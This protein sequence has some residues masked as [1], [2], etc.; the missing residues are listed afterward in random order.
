M[1]AHDHDAVDRAGIG[2]VQYQIPKLLGWIF[3]EQATSDY[4]VDGHVEVVTDG[5]P[6]GRLVGLQIKTGKSQFV[7][8]T[9]NGWLYRPSSRHIDYWLR[10][11]LPVYLLLV[12]TDKEAIHWQIL[13]EST[14]TRGPRGGRIVEVPE[15]NTIHNVEE[16]WEQAASL[17]GSEARLR[18]TENLD[19]LPPS[20]SKRLSRLKETARIASEW[21]AAH[22]AMGRSAPELTARTLLAN[23]PSWMADL[24]PEAWLIVGHYA[25][26][27]DAPFEAADA[28]ERA[29][30]LNPGIE[31]R[32]KFSAGG[33][34]A[35]VDPGRARDLF[36]QASCSQDASAIGELGLAALELGTHAEARPDEE[37]IVRL[38]ALTDD[39]VALS[40]LARHFSNLGQR[41]EAV[42][43]WES[44]LA[45]DPDNA[46]IFCGLSTELDRRA[47][48]ADRRPGDLARATDLAREAVE[49]LH[50][51]SGPSIDALKHLLHLLLL[52]NDYAGILDRALAAPRG[53]ATFSEASHPE[54]LTAAV[55]AADGLGD[56]ELVRELSGRLPDG[57]YQDFAKASLSENDRLPAKD[58]EEIWR[59]V[60]DGLD[61]SRP[62]EL[63]IT[64][65]R[66]AHLGV[67]ATDRLVPLVDAQLV[68]A[69]RV[70]LIRSIAAA[71]N[72]LDTALPGF[73]AQADVD[74]SAA[75]TLI[76]LLQ[77][78]GRMED[79]ITATE[80]A[81]T[82]FSE[83][84]FSLLQADLL[85]A[86]SRFD[87]ASVVLAS[88][89]R[90]ACS[91]G[92][93]PVPSGLWG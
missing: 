79:A 41:S 24:G 83:P 89:L 8:K 57:T 80:D 86:Q 50:R 23:S 29:A 19:H 58:R 43:L 10:H 17:I 14:I 87:D 59:N 27:H 67:D 65:T 25:Y 1:T 85:C 74:Q 69:D 71:V 39:V 53:Q 45:L 21:L 66:L 22:L 9:E 68:A 93:E 82:R 81:A 32:M 18:F 16:H 88:I 84:R 6:S 62:R 13:D 2:F 20:V 30:E 34:I 42:R 54:V 31:G 5:Q 33:A 48:S 26:N 76:Q 49:Q 91:Y 56:H 40:F 73:R 35:A 47:R 38:Q 11:S 4:G 7:E 63:A 52:D 28:Y 75:Y 92:V 61:A 3:R 51:W 37:L 12:D 46:E 60:L 55:L 90:A 36:V 15:T 64:A 72:D 77:D 78:G 44:A 70:D